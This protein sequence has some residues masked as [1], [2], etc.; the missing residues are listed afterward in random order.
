MAKVKLDDTP[1]HVRWRIHALRPDHPCMVCL[2]GLRRSDASLGMA[3]MLDDPDDVA[4][5]SEEEKA[6]ILRG[7]V[8]RF[9]M[10]VPAHAV[11][12]FV[13]PA[14][15]LPRIGGIGAQ[16]YDAYPGMMRVDRPSRCC[17]GCEFT[18]LTATALDLR[19]KL[20]SAE[21]QSIPQAT[22]RA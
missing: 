19:R 16:T 20:A 7:N 1:Q 11:L 6:A 21:R 10:S 4:G 13:G 15:G 8:F 14:I 22:E 17:E 18:E 2:G 3:G 9:S 12:Q 5:L